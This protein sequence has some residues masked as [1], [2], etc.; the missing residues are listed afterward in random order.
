VIFEQL[1]A[2]EGSTASNELV[3]ELGLVV[4]ASALLVDLLVGVLRVSCI[5]WYQSMAMLDQV[6]ETEGLR[7]REGQ[8][9]RYERTPTE[10][11]RVQC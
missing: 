10:R 5:L 6:R 2:L 9:A 7:G 8:G 1:E 11:H 4:V 3:G